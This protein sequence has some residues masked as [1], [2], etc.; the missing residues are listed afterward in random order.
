MQT[1]ITSYKCAVLSQVVL[2]MCA[3]HEH[4]LNF[5]WHPLPLF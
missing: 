4:G 5:T 2:S 3:V 1:A